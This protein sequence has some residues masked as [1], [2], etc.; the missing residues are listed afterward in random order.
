[1]REVRKYKS[2]P[3]FTIEFFSNTF[4]PYSFPTST[5]SF[6]EQNLP[7]NTQTVALTGEWPWDFQDLELFTHG[8]MVPVLKKQK[9]WGCAAGYR[10]AIPLTTPVFAS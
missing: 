6:Q 10:W 4:C 2:F 8:C 1:M 5:L 7:E 3:P 9:R